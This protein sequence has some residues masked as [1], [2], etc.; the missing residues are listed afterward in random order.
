[1]AFGHA[2]GGK[3]RNQ[4]PASRPT[5]RAFD[6]LQRSFPWVRNYTAWNE[7]NHCS[8]PTC[9]KPERAAAFYD[10]I[11]SGCPRCTVVA[12]DVLDQPNMVSWLHRFRRAARHKPTLW[13]MHNYLDANRLRTTGTR[14]ML[15]AVKGRVW[16]TETGGLVYR[17]H[18][19]A[20]I[21]FPESAPHA[22]QVTRF[23]FKFADTQPRLRRIYLYQWNANS[24][25]QTW[26]SGLI[27]S[28]NNTRPAFDELARYMGRDPKK[29]PARRAGA[30]RH[31]PAAARPG[32]PGSGG[33]APAATAAAASAKDPPKKAAAAAG[34]L[35]AA[36][37]PADRHDGSDGSDGPVRVPRRR[38]ALRQ[39]GVL[40]HQLALRAVLR[41]SG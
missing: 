5:R 36:D 13:G 15:K 40:G 19:R 9:H 6:A 23:L 31:R 39:R 18:Y 29:V 28:F 2:W 8:Q 20:Q 16:I 14:R 30:G 4:L 11:R 32:R 1:M 3:A 17:K 10:V 25:L 37:V 35:A 12:G 33:A 26:D 7:A 41:R 22:A 21:A 38:L 34:L 27:D 24:L